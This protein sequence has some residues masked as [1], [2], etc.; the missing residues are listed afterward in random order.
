MRKMLLP[1]ILELFFKGK[2]FLTERLK[3]GVTK[4]RTVKALFFV[5]FHFS[6]SKLIPSDQPSIPLYRHGLPMGAQ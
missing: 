5:I 1:L 3:Y 6:L 4:K 2:I